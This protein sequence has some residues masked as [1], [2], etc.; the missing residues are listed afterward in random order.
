[1]TTIL[2]L[3]ELI[4]RIYRKYEAVIVPV[5]KFIIALI[6]LLQI[7]SSFGYNE[8][9]SAV[10]VCL[11]LALLSSVLP[12]GATIFFSAVVILADFYALSLEIF[13][14]TAAV[15][16]IVAL[17]YLRFSPKTGYM[18]VLTPLSFL[19]HIPF[20]MPAAGALL[21]TPTSAVSVAC[22]T[23]LY[24]YLHGIKETAPALLAAE[25][26]TAAEKVTTIVNQITGNREM[27][28]VLL[29]FVLMTVMIYVI[30]RMAIKRSWTIA[31]IAGF[32]TEFLILIGGFLTL[33]IEGKTLALVLGNLASVGLA[34]V[35]KFF[36][37]HVDYKRTERVQFEDDDYYYYVRAIPKIKMPVQEKKVK[38]ITG[39]SRHTV[40]RQEKKEE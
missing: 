11:I 8:K 27:I 33:G 5:I 6:L 13:L 15:F 34:F 3:K 10:P 40:G 20:I 39:E 1:M 4:R 17:I 38:K 16:A 21:F 31:I 35:L 22:G 26:S 2:E 19:I 9:L 25:D 37:F 29:V 23:F 12:L 24:Y 30:R 36:F 14:S 32:M 28:L 7:R 18:V